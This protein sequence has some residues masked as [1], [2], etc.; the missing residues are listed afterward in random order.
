MDYKNP[1]AL[2]EI[3]SLSLYKINPFSNIISVIKLEMNSET[4]SWCLVLLPN[5]LLHFFKVINVHVM[6]T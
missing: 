6:K 5:K 2:I 4:V 1:L 3:W